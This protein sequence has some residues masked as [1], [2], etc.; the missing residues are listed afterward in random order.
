MLKL[1]RIYMKKWNLFE[2][3]AEGRLEWP[4]RIRLADCDDDER[5]T[6]FDCEMGI[7]TG[8]T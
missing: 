7:K 4:K 2:D 8:I 6:D 5:C 3:F 1:E